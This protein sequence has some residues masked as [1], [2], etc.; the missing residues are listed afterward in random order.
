[1]KTFLSMI[2][3]LVGFTVSTIMLFTFM[4][5]GLHRHGASWA[6][7]STGTLLVFGPALVITGLRKKN[8]LMV[9]GLSSG[10]WSA[11]LFFS[12]PVYFPGE[13]NEALVT[14]AATIGIQLPETSLPSE[15]QISSP[16]IPEAVASV[17]TELV[18]PTELQDHQ[19]ALP[20]EGQGRRLT[21]EIAVEHQD[22]LV[23][24][25]MMLDTGATYTTLPRLI[26][27][28]LGI[29]SSPKNP[30]IKLQT[31][32]GERTA[33]LVLI[34]KLWLGDLAIEGVAIAICDACASE[35][36][37]GLLGLNV[38]GGY[39]LTID[40]D[41]KEVIFTTRKTYSRH[42]DI[43]PFIDIEASISRFQGGRIEVDA[44]IQNNGIRTIANASVSIACG[45]QEWL[46]PFQDIE[47]EILHETQR[48]LP[49]HQE[50]EKYEI[51]LKSAAW[52]KD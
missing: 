2:T 43:K 29:P 34:D 4:G 33:E 48:T 38:T 21:V 36:T 19:I 40:A 24:I 16:P 50:C 8:Q 14:G 31:A 44:A 18:A 27:A 26:L 7:A 1:M 25:D 35:H 51:G 45:K 37:S 3:F 52:T 11:L 28:T 46:I 9:F 23:E 17:A 6:I 49:K 41:R 22:K 32:N 13:R 47:P 20:Y 10:I 30:Q 12:L 42:L 39:N 15:P 5:L